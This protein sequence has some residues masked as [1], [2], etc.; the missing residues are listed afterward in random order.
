MLTNNTISG[1]GTAGIRL[2]SSII[3]ANVSSNTIYANG[4]QGIK[5]QDDISQSSIVNNVLY[6]NAQIFTG[7]NLD[8]SG[9]AHDNTIYGNQI[10]YINN[11]VDTQ[12]K[13]GV[14]IAPTTATFNN[15][16]FIGLNNWFGSGSTA[17]FNDQ[18]AAGNQ[19]MNNILGT[20]YSVRND[21]LTN[22]QYM[23][24]RPATL[25][26]VFDSYHCNL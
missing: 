24:I 2:Q 26:Y 10:L 20:V 19:V 23:K 6:N 9:K 1:N 13:Y 5:L 15:Q 16:N 11:G 18:S 8:I 12:P 4:A 7:S 17:D 25:T 22:Y 14:N 21:F 3:G